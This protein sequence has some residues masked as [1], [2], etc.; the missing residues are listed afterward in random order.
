MACTFHYLSFQKWSE[1]GVF[2][3]NVLRATAACNFS[4]LIWP[5]GSAPAA[6]AS[7]LFDRPE[8]QIVWKNTV[9]RDFPTFSR[10]WIFFLLRLSLFWSSFFFSSLLFSDSSHLCFSSVHIVGS[11]T[12]KLPP[13]NDCIRSCQGKLCRAD[14]FLLLICFPESACEGFFVKRSR[15]N[16]SSHLHISWSTSSHL[17]ICWST[18]SHPHICWS[19]SSHLHIC[20]YT[21][22]HP[23]TCWSTSSHSHICRSTSSHPHTCWSTSSHLHACRSTSSHLHACRSTS[24]HPHICWSTSSHPHTCRSTSS[25][26]HV[27]RSPIALL[28]ISLLR[29]GRCRRSAT[30]R[31]PFARNGR[32]TSKT[33]VNFCKIAILVSRAQPF[34]TKWTLD[35]KNW[36]KIAILVSPSQPFRTKWTLDVKN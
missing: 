32:W 36:G 29:R 31:N 26:L 24:S 35:V 23:H 7:L 11:L 28:S 25:H 14:W 6:L 4:S 22:S 33:E 27:C 10:T 9:F 15:C 5:A 21:S 19:T 3:R 18:S 2:C 13:M 17:H 30:K 20:W 12:S 8:P 1:P 34:R 16:T